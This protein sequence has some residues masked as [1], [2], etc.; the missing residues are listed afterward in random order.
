MAELITLDEAKLH[1]RID[2]SEDDPLITVYIAA[3]LEACSKHIGKAIG[4]EAGQ[5][6][7]T[8]GIKAG[9]LMFISMLYEYRT[10]ISDVEA[11]RVPFAIES[12]WSVY[13]DL[14]VM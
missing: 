3:S 12:L 11:K 1:C 8:P 10:S 14:G 6:P 4:D 9:C 2:S 13:R 5:Q 7:F